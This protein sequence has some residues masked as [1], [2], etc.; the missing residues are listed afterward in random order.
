MPQVRKDSMITWIVQARIICA[1]HM[2][3]ARFVLQYMAF[4]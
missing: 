1:G 4:V 3:F 2:A